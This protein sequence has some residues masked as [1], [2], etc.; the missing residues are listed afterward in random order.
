M[1]K[2]YHLKQQTPMIHFQSG[3]EG[4]T[5]R[6][7]EVKPKLDRF[8]IEQCKLRGESVPDEWYVNPEKHKDGTHVGQVIK[9]ALKYKMRFKADK[10]SKVE[11]I[12]YLMF[13]ANMG[14]SKKTKMIVGDCDMTIICFCSDLAAEIEECLDDF[15]IASTF[16]FMQGKGFGGYLCGDKKISQIQIAKALQ[17]VLGCGKVYKVQTQLRAP[18]SN[19]E[20]K[21]NLVKIFDNIIKPFHSLMKSGINFKKY[22]R[23]YLF[24]YFHTKKGICY[25]NDK[26]FVKSKGIA[27]IVYK[28]DNA[29]KGEHIEPFK[30]Y[31]Y[32]RALL[33]I[34][35][36]IEYIS[37]LGEN[38]KPIG[39]K[40]GVRIKNTDDIDRYASP[41]RYRI[42]CGCVYVF[43]VP[44][45][46]ELFGSCFKFSSSNG[47]GNI[48]VPDKNDFDIE[49]FLSKFVQHINTNSNAREAANFKNEKFEEV[50]LNV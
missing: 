22:E 50:K 28:K 12:P 36:R 39:K 15:F 44:I 27:P 29:K 4:A 21:V 1:V 46:D 2:I 8:I 11:D 43:A 13:Y 20:K 18:V 23:S 47:A 5:L 38:D 24:Q 48:T 10:N 42:I 41:V 9:P 33:G 31:K 3:E 7:G 34:T 14:K 35:E 37:G 32:V 6:A 45:P 16:G 19:E 40:I 30:N 25:G 17:N 49:D 26:A